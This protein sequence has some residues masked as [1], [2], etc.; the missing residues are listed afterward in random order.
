M[1]TRLFNVLMIILISGSFAVGQGTSLGIL[2]GVNMQTLNG[3]DYQGDKLDNDMIVGYHVGLNLQMPIAPEFYFQPGLMFATKGAANTNGGITT[4]HNFSYIELPLNLVYKGALGNGF[5]MVGFGPYLAYA[6]KGKVKYEGGAAAYTS[7]VEF[8][9]VVEPGDPLLTPYFKAF[10]AGGNIFAGY[11][12]AA[13]I[14]FQLDTQLGL[15]K[16][17]PED[18]RFPDSKSEIKNTGFGLSLGYRF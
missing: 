8:K 2:G 15:V 18:K 7:D 10:D 3:K 12:T 13:G 14:F 1:K 9:N 5:V 4:T 17:N 6:L 16:I 11:E